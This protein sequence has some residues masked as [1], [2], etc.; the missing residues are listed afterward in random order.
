MLL[1]RRGTYQKMHSE[2]LTMPDAFLLPAVTSM[3]RKQ[4]A[5]FLHILEVYVDDFIQLAE[6]DNKEAL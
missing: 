5:K 6:T 1:S 3:T 4:G 2:D